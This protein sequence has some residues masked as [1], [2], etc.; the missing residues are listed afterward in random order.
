[1]RTR[2]LCPTLLLLA[3]IWL[4][5]GSTMAAE[6][7]PPCPAFD[8]LDKQVRDGSLSKAEAERRFA[9]L[10]AELDA[11]SGGGAATPWIVP[12][13]GYTLAGA[14]ADAARGYVA[15]G[16]D[17]F[18]GNRHGGHPSYDLFIADRNRD[19]L[20]DLSGAP[21]TVVAMTG[22]I[23]VAAETSWAADS[24]LRGGNYLWI[25]DPVEHLLFYYAHNRDLLVGV[26]D[27][28]EPGTPIATVGRSGFNA[29]KQR[30]PT[31]L[32]LTVLKIASGHPSPLNILPQLRKARTLPSP[33]AAQASLL[34]DTARAEKHPFRTETK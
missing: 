2:L 19:S 32:H 7:C 20:D 30:S 21:V 31:H 23:V 27:R 34:T 15:A 12:L 9:G 17:Y 3:A 13:H 33:Y 4:S 29:A 24:P 16:Y 22:G 26:G 28:V 11:G 8:R 10:I 1:M 6:P 25:Y 18:A 14:G 5:T